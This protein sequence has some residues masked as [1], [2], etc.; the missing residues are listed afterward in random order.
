MA[1]PEQIPVSAVYDRA[2]CGY[3]ITD[4]DGTVLA[5]N[6]T[7]LDW[8]GLER[9][10][11][12]ER[13]TF[14]SLLSAGGRIYHETHYAPMLAMQDSAHEIALDVVCADG[15]RLSVL[16]NS[17][18]ERDDA[19][20]PAAI[21]TAVFDATDR[22]EYERELLRQKER[23][24]ASETKAHALAHTLQQTL[25]P[26]A[27]PVIPGLDLDAIYRPAGSGDE[28]GGDFYDVFEIAQD[29]WVVVVGDVCG[30]GTEAAV[31]TSAAR[32]TI[33]GSAV[34]HPGSPEVLEVLNEVLLRHESHRFCTAVVV[35][36]RRSDGRW[37][38]SVT[39]AGHPLPLL[40]RPGQPV[41]EVGR[42]GS[43][44]GL[45][46]E[47]R[48]HEVAV[49]LDEGDVLVLFTDGVT[50]GRRGRE[51]YGDERLVDAV[52]RH[53]DSATSV[54]SGVLEELVEFQGDV[55]RDDIVVLA[56]SPRT[57]SDVT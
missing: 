21:H 37:T 25:I 38:A 28:V 15:T 56:V 57:A 45:V 48:F 24:E 50:E 51:F 49:A 16:V 7:F 46:T 13:R 36:M 5:V 47:P 39:A 53:A 20:T 54:C 4:P 31:V 23:A 33:R 41:V 1:R 9:D 32:H 11:L 19:G 17:V 14:A 18:L 52:A 44:V 42:H 3:L 8:T 55:P 12:V 6:Q 26:P 34:R 29:D 2:P 35:R 40:A 22:R 43:A 27:P 30:K 10:D